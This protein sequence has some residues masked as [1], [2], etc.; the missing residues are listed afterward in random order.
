MGLGTYLRNKWNESRQN[1]EIDYSKS[2][3]HRI[4]PNTIIFFLNSI[5]RDKQFYLIF[6]TCRHGLVRV[7]K[8]RPFSLV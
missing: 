7:W 8:S 3:E 4:K 1:L 6:L 5:I 2:K